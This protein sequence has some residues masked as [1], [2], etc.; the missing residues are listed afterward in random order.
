MDKKIID[1]SSWREARLTDHMANER[2]FLAWI[3]TSLG[4]MAFGFVIERFSFFTLQVANFLG[5]SHIQESTNSSLSLRE[6]S[7]NFG[8]LLVI[9][10]GLICVLSFIKYK[11]VQRNIEKGVYNPSMLLDLLL[12]LSVLSIGIFLLFF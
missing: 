5:K 2:T 6:Y 3:R 12:T 10:G 8:T 4:I 1:E 11:Q 7:S 9:I